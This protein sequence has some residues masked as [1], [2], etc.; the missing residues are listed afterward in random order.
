MSAFKGPSKNSPGITHTGLRSED[1]TT[2]RI[3]EEF[4]VQVGYEQTFSVR[5]CARARTRA[6]AAIFVQ[7]GAGKF[8][9]MCVRVRA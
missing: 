4:L 5:A 6:G 9:E 1:A 2:S 7:I 3:R 8:S